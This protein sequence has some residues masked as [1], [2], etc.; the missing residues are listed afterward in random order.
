MK[1]SLG[2][3]VLIFLLPVSF[4]ATI[5]EER[6]RFPAARPGTRVSPTP[7]PPPELAGEVADVITINTHL[8]TVPMRVL[9]SNGK[10]VAD[11][12]AEEFRVF[13]DGTE[14]QVAHFA[15]VNSP[16]TVAL[17]LDVSDST[18]ASQGEIKKAAIAFVD[19]LRPDDYVII[20][21]FDSLLNV[22]DQPTN[23][24]DALHGMIDAIRPG[25]GTRLYDGLHLVLE[26]LFT[27]IHGRKAIVLFTDGN[28]IDSRTSVNE[29]LREA[30]TAD[31][32]IFSIRYETSVAAR[33]K[34]SSVSV[35]SP[36]IRG[37]G[38]PTPPDARAR[39]YLKQLADKTGARMI[40]ATN[41]EKL[42]AAFALIAEEIRSQYSLGYY[43]STPPQPGQ[44]R[45]IKV[46]LTRPN[47]T[48]HARGA[49]LVPAPRR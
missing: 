26:R 45:K 3:S 5:R 42:T 13:E 33:Q 8:V 18:E 35:S 23:N 21:T 28:D 22:I 32:L 49:Y 25:K 14:Q 36:R 6:G 34:I 10:S 31:V 40:E 27:Q 47:V 41:S 12:R 29:S 37:T 4:L 1:V 17:M 46:L 44:R 9:D 16:F 11:M 24:R 30:E 39:N 15:S 7:T 43:P 20:I 48:V 38:D 19:Q 2:I